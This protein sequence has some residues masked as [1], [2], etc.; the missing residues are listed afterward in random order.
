MRKWYVADFETTN[1]QYYLQHGYTKVWLYAIADCDGVVIKYG[2]S[3]EDFISYCTKELSGKD[4]Y[5]H[6]LRFDGIFILDYLCSIGYVPDYSP[7]HPIRSFTTLIGDMGEFYSIDVIL[8]KKKQLHFRDS[9]K[10][11][12]FK[13]AYIAKSFNLPIQKEHIDYSDYTISP[14]TISYVSNDVS[15]VA[16]AL[17]EI[18]AHGMTKMTTASCAY[19]AFI[20][21]FSTQAIET[22]YPSLDTN[23]LKIW[24]DAYRGGR[25]QVNPIYKSKILNN[26]SRY[27]VNSMYPH[28][29]RNCPLPYGNPVTATADTIGNF[30]F[31]LMHIRVAFILKEGHMPSL[32]KKGGLYNQGDTYYI[33]SDGMEEL[34]ISTIDFKIM[35]R[36]Y[37]ILEYEYLDGYGFY[38]GTGLFKNYIDTWYTAKQHDKD[39][40][41]LVDKLMLNSLYG[42][43]GTNIEKRSKMIIYEDERIA[44]KYSEYEEGKHYYLPVAIAVVSYAH[45]IIDDAI[46]ATGYDNFVYC[47]TDSVH[48]LGTLPSSLV[49]NKQLGKFKLEGIED[50][51][52][53]VRQKCYITKEN[54]EVKITSAG[55]TDNMKEMLIEEYKDDIFNIFDVGLTCKGKLIPKRVKGGVIL[56]ETTFEIK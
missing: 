22:L 45:L 21:G 37:D 18:K 47:D 15:I 24:R 10:V 25:C 53:Y 7:K 48:T 4:I 36:H 14:T 27:D 34:Y 55:M 9:L 41:K 44:F 42:K 2:D 1:E 5:F 51:S 3:I 13:V 38:C 19:T 35:K 16:L 39:G 28:V 6:N 12:P 11:L 40:K 49:D 43:F 52:K 30:A 31:G 33:T 32:L 54:N 50:T 46:E 29:M 8:S 20:A 56:H 26:V 17:K 23:F